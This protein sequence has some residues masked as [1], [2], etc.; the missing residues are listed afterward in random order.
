M[1]AVRAPRPQVRWRLAAVTVMLLII[2]AGTYATAM[3]QRQ[4]RLEALRAERQQIESELQRVKAIADQAQPF[5][6]LESGD[7]R[8][9][10]NRD[11]PKQQ[12]L[13]YY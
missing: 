1:R 4:H 8:L 5:V 10:V 3:R 12:P 13:F 9:I 11:N 7:A 2:V 6:V